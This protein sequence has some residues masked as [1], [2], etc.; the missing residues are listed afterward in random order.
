MFGMGTG[1]TPLP[2][3]PSKNEH[4]IGDT[5]CKGVKR[6]FLKKSV[7]FFSIHVPSLNPAYTLGQESQSIPCIPSVK[8][9]AEPET[10]IPVPCERAYPCQ[11]WACTEHGFEYS[12]ARCS[13]WEEYTH[14]RWRQQQKSVPQDFL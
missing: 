1:V 10:C 13:L 14:E 3:L 6:F 11:K 2:W 4:I 5:F 7:I 12:N 8:P 9:L